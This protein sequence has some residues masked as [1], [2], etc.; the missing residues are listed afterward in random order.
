MMGL[1]AVKLWQNETFHCHSNHMHI[2]ILI[3]NGKDGSKLSCQVFV[4]ELLTTYLAIM[5]EPDGRTDASNDVT[6]AYGANN[7][8]MM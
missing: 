8:N 6:R 4:E 5:L 1:L 2:I 7:S 3:T